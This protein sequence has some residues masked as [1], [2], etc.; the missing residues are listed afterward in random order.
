MGPWPGTMTS[1][2]QPAILSHVSIHFVMLLLFAY[3]ATQ[4]NATSPANRILCCGRYA[5]TS[6]QVCAGPAKR[7]CT[8][9]LP[10]KYVTSSTNVTVGGTST[11]GSPPSATPGVAVHV[12]GVLATA[13]STSL[14]Q[15]GWLLISA[16]VKNWF[17]AT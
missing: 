14:R 12:F 15:Y 17:P 7:Y 4:K 3:G 1:T 10:M 16:P 5:I 13:F 8:S 11:R 9:V 2:S 6:P